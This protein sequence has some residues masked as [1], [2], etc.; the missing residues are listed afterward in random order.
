MKLFFKLLPLLLP[1]AVLAADRG[2]VVT[3]CRADAAKFCQDI[4]PGQ[5]RISACLISHHE[6]L[7]DDC[8]A[9]IHERREDNQRWLVECLPDAQKYCLRVRPGEGRIAACLKSHQAHLQD[10]CRAYFE[11]KSPRD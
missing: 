2:D 11:G 9:A 4:E 1:T 5:G 3:A 10:G 8:R 7:S 6:H